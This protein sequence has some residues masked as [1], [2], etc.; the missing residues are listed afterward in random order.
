M[1][2]SNFYN[3]FNKGTLSKV[4][5]VMTEKALFENM[6]E[7][8]FTNVYTKDIASF[9][10]NFVVTRHSLFFE[11]KKEDLIEMMW[12]FRMTKSEIEGQLRQQMS[13]NPELSIIISFVD[14][15]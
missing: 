14:E 5:S 4:E 3:G 10:Y 8:V 1:K 15:I 13:H 2:I 12:R 6:T 11:M 9:E 7:L